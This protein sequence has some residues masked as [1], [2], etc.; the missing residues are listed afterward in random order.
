MFS[1]EREN[2]EQYC[3]T[4]MTRRDNQGNLYEKYCSKTNLGKKVI[5]R[6]ETI[7][8]QIDSFWLIV[9]HSILKVNIVAIKRRELNSR[10][11]THIIMGSSIC[12]GI[13]QQTY[14][15]S[16]APE[17]GKHQRRRPILRK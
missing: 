1:C 17:S 14:A 12:P 8:T 15:V 9:V 6:K 5:L 10:I 13:Q 3:D 2:G 16:V 7:K 4:E 11:G